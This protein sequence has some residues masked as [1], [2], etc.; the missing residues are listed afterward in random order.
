[1]A[2]SS[3][4]QRLAYLA[5]LGGAVQAGQD[6]FQNAIARVRGMMTP[7][8]QAYSRITRTP[9]YVGN[10][11]TDMAGRYEH[12]AITIAPDQWNLVPHESAHAIYDQA[13][14]RNQAS[15]LLPYVAEG[16]RNRV[17]ADP[18]YQRQSDY[19]SPEEL[20]DEGL[21]FSIGDRGRA[22]YVNHVAD[23]ITDPAIAARLRRLND[24]A[25]NS[26]QP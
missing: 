16:A 15:Q 4:L 14:L 19:G 7:Q 8:P 10:P 24:I 1:M 18:F 3:K 22:G 11:G 6:W 21:A 9:I 5:N 20:T 25:L 13:A 26:R 2:D 23:T 17:L 12:G